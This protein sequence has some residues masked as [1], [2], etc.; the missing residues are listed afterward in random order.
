MC[1]VKIRLI[2]CGHDRAF[3]MPCDRHMG[4]D[5]DDCCENQGGGHPSLSLTVQGPPIA[6]FCPNC[7]CVQQQ[8]LAEERER[9]RRRNGGRRH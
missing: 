9:R 2:I 6:D 7:L 1:Q 3:D 4:Q 8:R 5:I